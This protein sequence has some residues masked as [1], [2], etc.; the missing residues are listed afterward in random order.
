[1]DIN[2]M[3]IAINHNQNGQ[4][5]GYLSSGNNQFG[6]SHPAAFNGV[7]CDGSVQTFTYS[8]DLTLWR[9]IGHRGDGAAISLP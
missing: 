5:N 6:S 9:R 4:S 1:M 2:G 3:I 7:M 8:I